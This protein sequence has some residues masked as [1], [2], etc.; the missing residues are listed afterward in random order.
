MPAD[1]AQGRPFVVIAE[2]RVKE[3]CMVAFLALARDDVEHSVADE[4][5]CRQLDVVAPVD[6]DGTVLFYEVYDGRPAFDAHLQ[7][8]HFK[9]FR[10]GYPALVSERRDPRFMLRHAP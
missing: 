7:T 8:P 6:E 5:G 10:D 1:P 4:P 3:G 9:R 2:F